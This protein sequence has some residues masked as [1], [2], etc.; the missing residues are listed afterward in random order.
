MGCKS[1]KSSPLCLALYHGSWPALHMQTFFC[2]RCVGT[3]YL[4]LTWL[5]R[6]CVLRRVPSGLGLVN[7]CG[8]RRNDDI[9][10]LQQ[11]HLV[12]KLQGYSFWLPDDA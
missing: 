6:C 3:K 2:Q 4:R 9:R 10:S 7:A 8:P 12:R 5:D 11:V 1:C